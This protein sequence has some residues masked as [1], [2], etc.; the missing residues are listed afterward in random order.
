M[1]IPNQIYMAYKIQLYLANDYF[2]LVDGI[3][4]AQY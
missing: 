4:V 2:F 3:R 1:Q